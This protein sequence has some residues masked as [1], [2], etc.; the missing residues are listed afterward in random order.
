M[1]LMTYDLHGAWEDRTGCVAPLYTTEEDETL[2]G[3]DICFGPN[4][5]LNNM[6]TC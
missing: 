6:E 4:V 3:G 1:N 5:Q 2:A